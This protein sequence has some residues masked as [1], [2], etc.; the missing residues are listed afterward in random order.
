MRKNNRAHNS[1]IDKL[2]KVIIALK[3]A[4]GK[5]NRTLPLNSKF[6]EKFFKLL[7]YLFLVGV[8]FKNIT[9]RLQVFYVLNIHIKFCSNL[10][11]FTIQSIKLFF[12]HNFKPS[13][14]EI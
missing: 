6:G 14:L 1:H 8:N 11:L 12:V 10:M 7:I 9:V 3:K 2:T 5:S 13:K 4:L